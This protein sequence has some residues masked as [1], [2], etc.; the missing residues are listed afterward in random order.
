MRWRS[1]RLFSA[2][3]S[4]ASLGS[5][6]APSISRRSAPPPHRTRPEVEGG[7]IVGLGLQV[8]DQRPIRRNL[9]AARR[10]SVQGRSGEHP[11]DRQFLG[12]G[13]GSGH[14]KG[15][16]K[17]DFDHPSSCQA[18]ARNATAIAPNVRRRYLP[19]HSRSF[20]PTRPPAM[21]QQYI[22]QMQGLTKAYAGGKK[23]F[24]NIWLSFYSWRQDRHRRRQRLG[25][26][27]PDEDHGRHGQ[28]SIRRRRAGPPMACKH[29]LPVAGAAAGPRH[30]S[31]CCG[32]V[33]EGS[34]PPSRRWSDRYNE[35]AAQMAED[36]T[37]E[38][39]GRR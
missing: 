16:G 38:T 7:L 22:F 30:S 23:V 11:G 12:G 9:H 6:L 4:T 24:E 5:T 32:N 17:N 14:G 28:R 13:N 15:D 18:N 8:G 34:A 29:G 2:S 20:I 3:D 10:R 33:M 39:D 36:Y 37:D 25:Q 1:R 21:A 26:V 35:I 27:H 19:R 31:M